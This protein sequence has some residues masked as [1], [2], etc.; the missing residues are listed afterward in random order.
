M[1]ELNNSELNLNQFYWEKANAC[2]ANL[3]NDKRVNKDILKAGLLQSETSFYNPNTD[4]FYK[5]LN[6]L[7]NIQS[8]LKPIN[9]DLG[10][11]EFDLPA[12]IESQ[13]KNLIP[14]RKG[15]FKFGSTLVESE[16]KSFLK[17]DRF[18]SYFS[19]LT[20]SRIIDIGCGNGYYMFRMLEH[21]PKFVLGVDPSHLTFMQYYMVQHFLNDSRLHYLP[22]GW[23][24]LTGFRQFFDVVICMGI[25]YHHRSPVD[26][27]KM[28]RLISCQ[29]MTLFFDTL[30]IDGNDDYILFPEDRY[31]KMPNV[32]FLPTVSALKNIMGRAGF[33]K[34]EIL[35]IDKTTDNEQ[36][37]TPWTFGKSLADFLDPQ[38]SSKTIEGYPAP[39]RIAL[40]AQ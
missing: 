7:P 10:M 27:F 26:L 33:K 34:I 25:M 14:W 12:S 6:S 11:I 38:D 5:S 24:D 23:N 4:R 20:D 28:I 13:L 3:P 35:S 37:V 16:W 40:I 32:Y 1:I 36:R 31:A 18:S 17:W 29:S 8:K 21:L 30:I 39:K 22:L 2:L 15:P 19:K 9:K